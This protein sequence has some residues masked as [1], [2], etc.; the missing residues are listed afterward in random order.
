MT[1]RCANCK[2]YFV[3]HDPKKPWGCRKFNFKSSILPNYE[4][5]SATGMECAYHTLKRLNLS[6]PKDIK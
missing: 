4:V 6:A 1:I 3:T 5:K 2:F